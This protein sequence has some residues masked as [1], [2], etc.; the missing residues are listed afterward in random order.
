LKWEAKRQSIENAIG[1]IK[2]QSLKG[3]IEIDDYLSL[4]RLLSGR[5]AKNRMR[6]NK[7]LKLM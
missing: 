4:V 6:M 2:G 5:V 3:S 7:L 1:Y